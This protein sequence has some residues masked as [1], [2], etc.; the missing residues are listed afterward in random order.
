MA[1]PPPGSA[2][3]SLSLM[4]SAMELNFRFS[5]VRGR[6]E[7][8]WVW[9]LLGAEEYRDITSRSLSSSWIVGGHGGCLPVVPDTPDKKLVDTEPRSDHPDRREDWLDTL[10][11]SLLS[12]ARLREV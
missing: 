9:R 2:S 8:S 11:T 1:A 7:D 6:Q 5:P 12:E 4:A 10:C 3:S